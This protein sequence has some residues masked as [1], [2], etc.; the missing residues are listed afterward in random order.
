MTVNGERSRYFGPDGI[1]VNFAGGSDSTNLQSDMFW[2]SVKD[3]GLFQRET[4]APAPVGPLPQVRQIYQGFADGYNAYLASGSL[5][6]PT[7]AGQPWVRL[8]TMEDLFL[9]MAQIVTTP[10]SGALI[11]DEA[12][13][14][15]PGPQSVGPQSVGSQSATTPPDPAALAALREDGKSSTARRWSSPRSSRRPGRWPRASS[16]TRRRPTRSPRGTRT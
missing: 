13:A 7:C 6:D 11:S 3:S 12:A 2:Q 1:A 8:I 9:R 5:H 4:S 15:P 16:P 10:S 14:A